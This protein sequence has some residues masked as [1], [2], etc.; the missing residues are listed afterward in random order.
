MRWRALLLSGLFA[1]SLGL[2][3][4]SSASADPPPWA[5]RWNH[6]KHFKGGGS[7]HWRHD[8][9]WRNDDG[10]WWRRRDDTSWRYR[11][12]DDWR[13]DRGDS[14]RYR[15]DDDRW[16]RDHDH[17]YWRRN[18]DW[19]GRNDRY[20]RYDSYPRYGGNF[21]GSGYSAACG[22]R[23]A[24]DRAKI[25]EIGPSGRHRKAL[26]WFQDDLNNA[27]RDGC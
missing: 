18:H 20:D 2:G 27:M 24:R 4:T 12:D 14:W 5:G 6:N 16:Y 1:A 7:D 26:R 10:D 17:D 8:R 25:A 19:W 11:R 15:H 23:I 3:F 9:N 13:W 22:D 21:R